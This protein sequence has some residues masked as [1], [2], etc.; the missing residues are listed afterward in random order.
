M[1]A[2]RV[3]LVLVVEDHRDTRELY[4]DALREAGFLARGTASVDAA[5]D[6]LGQL[7]VDALVIDRSIGDSLVSL[8]RGKPRPRLIA[9]TGRPPEAG[10]EALYDAY[11][12]KPC[13]PSDLVRAVRTALSHA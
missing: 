3:V 8:L 5:L 7:K 12:L 4:V 13:L 9:V 1:T 6:L 10:E 2:D 11:L